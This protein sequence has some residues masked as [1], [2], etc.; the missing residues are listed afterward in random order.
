MYIY[1]NTSI[2][3]VRPVRN[4]ITSGPNVP[5]GLAF[6]SSKWSEERLFAYAYAYEQATMVRDTVKPYIL[7]NTQV[8]PNAVA[9]KSGANHLCFSIPLIF[10][11]GVALFSL[12]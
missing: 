12:F 3:T 4:L 1:I 6:I 8:Q 9:T 11:L 5:F 2:Y 10:T 7:P